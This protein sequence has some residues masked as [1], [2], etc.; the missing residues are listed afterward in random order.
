[1]PGNSTSAY[2][3]AQ[4]YGL[5]AQAVAYAARFFGVPYVYGGTTPSGFDCSGLVQYVY[6]KL[7]IKLPR[8]TFEQ[9][10]VGIPV[11]RDQ[12]QPGD[13]L[14]FN[15]G[16]GST[17]THPG[18]EAIYAGNGQMI[19][20]P[21]T[22]DVVKKTAVN[23]GAFVGARRVSGDPQGVVP[24]NGWATSAGGVSAGGSV[25]T[26]QPV[27]FH[28]PGVPWDFPWPWEIPGKVTGAAAG[29]VGDAVGD[30]IS[31][32]A[33]GIG[34]ILTRVSIMAPLLVAGAA[35]IVLGFWRGTT[36]KRG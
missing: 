14:F 25:A 2:A 15:S 17:P 21:H 4:G 36:S 18:H 29:A 13:I 33:S 9:Y 35:L 27:G 28:I 19:V 3:N 26:V 6:N 20:A 5:G 31:N 32:A 34:R 8:T 11:S 12:L 24:S 1:M 7:G 22:G 30:S 16:P 23:W 10:K